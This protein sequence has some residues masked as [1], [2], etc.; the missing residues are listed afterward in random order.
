MAEDLRREQDVFQQAAPQTAQRNPKDPKGENRGN[1]RLP[2][3]F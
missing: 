1:A 2:V 3:S